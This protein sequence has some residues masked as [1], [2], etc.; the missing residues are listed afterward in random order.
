MFITTDNATPTRPSTVVDTHSARLKALIVQG[1]NAKDAINQG[2][3]M[4]TVEYLA[5][6]HEKNEAKLRAELQSAAAEAGRAIA[7]A[8]KGIAKRRAEAVEADAASYDYQRLGIMRSEIEA[9][10]DASLPPMGETRYGQLSA[11]LDTAL[12][13]GDRHAMRATA[14]VA[15]ARISP[16][17]A[18]ASGV[19]GLIEQ[20]HEALAPA[21]VTELDVQLDELSFAAMEYAGVAYNFEAEIDAAGGWS[22]GRRGLGI[23]GSPEASP[24]A[25]ALGDLPPAKQMPAW[26]GDSV[27][28]PAAPT[29]WQRLVGVR[30]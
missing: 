2:R 19:R 30:A 25:V 6:A 29:D 22:K 21:G 1:A 11:A 23:F 18:D 14:S 15:Q 28:E 7:F 13:A 26:M 12:R 17:D 27:N 24:V 10:F 5:E 16:T 9:R 8:Y 20:I 3:D 4:F